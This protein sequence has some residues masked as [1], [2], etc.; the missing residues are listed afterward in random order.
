MQVLASFA[1]FTSTFQRAKTLLKIIGIYKQDLTKKSNYNFDF[2][3]NKSLNMTHT[4]NTYNLSH[5]KIVNK[6]G[7]Q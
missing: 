7:Q 1:W 3:V 6:L 5:E 2:I 4:L